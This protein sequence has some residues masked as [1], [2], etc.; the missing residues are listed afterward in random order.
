VVSI[1]ITGFIEVLFKW[2]SKKL[3]AVPS[4]LERTVNS[5]LNYRLMD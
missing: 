1:L 2:G 3:F 4:P 5:C